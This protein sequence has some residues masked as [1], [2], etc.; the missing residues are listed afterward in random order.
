MTDTQTIITQTLSNIT[1]Q[2][3]IIHIGTHMIQNILL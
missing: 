3:H 2:I 1:Y